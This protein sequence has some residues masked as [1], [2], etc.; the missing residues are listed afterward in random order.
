[1]AEE[2]AGQTVFRVV[3]RDGFRERDVNFETGQ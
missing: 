2:A 1:M 3:A